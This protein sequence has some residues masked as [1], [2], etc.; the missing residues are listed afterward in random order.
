LL[1]APSIDSQ[2]Q[3]MP[4]KASYSANPARQKRSKKPSW[5]QA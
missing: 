4:L 2:L 5:T 3:S 1:I